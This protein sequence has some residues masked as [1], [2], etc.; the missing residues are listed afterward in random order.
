MVMAEKKHSYGQ[1]VR[2]AAQ[3]HNLFDDPSHN[4]NSLTYKP[5]LLILH[6]RKSKVLIF[7]N[8]DQ[9]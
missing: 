9:S 4:N 1:H 8:I 3:K 7:I 2:Y 5:P 6:P